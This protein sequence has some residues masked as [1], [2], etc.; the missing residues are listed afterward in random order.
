MWR[1]GG[2][3][4]LETQRCSAWA[5]GPSGAQNNHFT[6]M[7]CGTEAV[8]YLRLTDSC[9]TQLKA[10]GPSRTCNESKEEKKKFDTS[11]PEPDAVNPKPS[12]ANT[13]P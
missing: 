7:Y 10:E 13:Q 11:H 5:S 1:S 12:A 9:T 3:G 6:E 8:S 4:W 2:A